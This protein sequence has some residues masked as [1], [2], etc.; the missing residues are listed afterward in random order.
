[1][2]IQKTSLVNI[3]IERIKNSI[4]ENKLKPNDK[5]LTEKE[6]TEQLKV[7]RTVVREALISLQ[8]V[9][10]SKIKPGGGELAAVAAPGIAHDAVV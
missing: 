4:L 5:F 8:A 2:E 3:V 6:L 1:M 10:I 7:S 9:G